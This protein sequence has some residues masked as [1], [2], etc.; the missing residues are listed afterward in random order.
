MVLNPISRMLFTKQHILR[1]IKDVVRAYRANKA[2]EEAR[3]SVLDEAE[4]DMENFS[5]E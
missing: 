2:I 4:V 3:E 5:V 1:M